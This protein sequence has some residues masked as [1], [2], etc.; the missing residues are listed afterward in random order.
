MRL[1][2]IDTYASTKSDPCGDGVLRC[3][4]SRCRRA[5]REGAERRDDEETVYNESFW[6][7]SLESEETI[8]R[9]GARTKGADCRPHFGDSSGACQGQFVY[10][11]TQREVGR[12]DGRGDEAI[13]GVARIDAHG[14]AGRKDVAEAGLRFADGRSRAT[15]ASRQFFV[16]SCTEL[17]PSG[18]PPLTNNT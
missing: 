12:R 4:R 6:R 3:Y 8:Q 1:L 13:P 18:S 16:V 11:K 9:T 2:F 7:P 5:I 17:Q 15:L 10:R 14:Q